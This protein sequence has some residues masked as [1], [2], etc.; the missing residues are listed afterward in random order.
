MKKLSNITLLGVA[1]LSIPLV[2]HYDVA[3]WFNSEFV[4][5]IEAEERMETALE[6]GAWTWNWME[7]PLGTISFAVLCIQ[8]AR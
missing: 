3:L 1:V 6:V 2:F 8:L 4:S 7:P 5:H